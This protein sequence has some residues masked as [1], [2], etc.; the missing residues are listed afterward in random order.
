MKFHIL[1]FHLENFLFSGGKQVFNEPQSFNSQFNESNCFISD[2]IDTTSK[3]ILYVPSKSVLDDMEFNISCH[4]HE[5]LQ[6]SKIPYQFIEDTVKD[7]NRNILELNGKQI[8][9][10]IALGKKEAKRKCVENAWRVLSETHEMVFKDEITHDHIDVIEKKSLIKESY[11]SAPKLADTNIGS[12]L[13]RKMGWDGNSGMGKMEHGRVDPVFLEGVEGRSGVGHIRP[14]TVEKKSV[15]Q[16][17]FH[18][19]RDSTQTEIRFSSDLTKNDRALVHRL[20]QKYRLKHKSFGKN[21][22]RY[23]VVSKHS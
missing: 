14:E 16:S 12:K 2:H 3:L 1:N 19:I 6:K 21:E 4:L 17:L 13:L 15:E 8:G 23:M 20:C 7:Q 18:F 11:I 5:S 9:C 10:G 22:D